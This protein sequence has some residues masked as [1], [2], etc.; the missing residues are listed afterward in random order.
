MTDTLIPILPASPLHFD[1]QTYEAKRDHARLFEQ[2]ERVRGA[3]AGAGPLTIA[4]IAART[5]DPE[6]SVGAR[7]RDLRKA[8]FGGHTVERTYAG[9]GLF[10]YQL[11]S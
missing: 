1:G 5:G 8:R 3:M 9:N 11:V 4:E 2:L 7:T 10:R 6:S